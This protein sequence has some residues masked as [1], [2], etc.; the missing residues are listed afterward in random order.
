[1]Q[2]LDVISV[3]IWQILISL[4][5][6]AILYVLFKKLLYKPVQAVIEKRRQ[7]I[8][9]QY[10]AAAAAE[11]NAEENRELYAQKMAGAQAEAEGII[12]DA[13]V[14][15][16]RR[17]DSIVNDARDKADA[18][19]RQA[20]VEAELEKKKA[21]QTIRQEIADVSAALAEKL[22]QREMSDSDHRGLI[23]SFLDEIG[24]EHDDNE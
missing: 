18:I 19:V 23:D 5:N 6:L 12:K 13:T 4:A 10:A 16:G 11:K 24:D 8:D 17:S 22:L 20:Q 1:M 9:D 3:N 2:S 14:N 21:Q 15:A 7:A